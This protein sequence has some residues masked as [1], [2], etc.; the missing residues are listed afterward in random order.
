[1]RI[2]SRIRICTSDQWIQIGTSDQWIQIRI[3]NTWLKFNVWH[4]FRLPPTP[5]PSC[6]AWSQTWRR[7]SS[8]SLRSSWPTGQAQLFIELSSSLSSDLHWAQFFID[9]S[10]SLSSA[11]HWAQLF[12]FS[13]AIFLLISIVLEQIKK[14]RKGTC[15]SDQA[16]CRLRDSFLASNKCQNLF[17][18]RGFRFIFKVEK[19]TYT[20]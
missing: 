13:L 18:N 4:R 3:P 6:T 8:A 5:S 1:M 9:L 11:V 16:V 2:R 20:K 17:H 15:L 10:C 7:S 12:I 14:L 19:I